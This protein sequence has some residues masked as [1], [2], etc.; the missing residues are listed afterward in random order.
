MFSTLRSGKER[1]R[2]RFLASRLLL[3]LDSTSATTL[4]ISGILKFT[5]A[6]SS[7][8]PGGSATQVK[9]ALLFSPGLK[10][11]KRLLPISLP[12]A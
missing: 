11:L 12:F 5:T 1:L 2:L 10:E 3:L 4:V 8:F 6:F 9:V 7:T